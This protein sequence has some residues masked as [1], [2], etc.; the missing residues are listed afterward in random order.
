MTFVTGTEA[1]ASVAPP[2]L[3]LA[4]RTLDQHPDLYRVLRRMPDETC[5]GI[6]P[7]WGGPSETAL[8][9]PTVR[10][11][12][13]VDVET[14]GLDPLTDKIIEFAAVKFTFSP[15]TGQ[16]LD[17]V[18]M[19]QSYE[20]PGIAIPP[21]I[22][23][24]TGITDADV[25]GKRIDDAE[26]THLLLDCALVVAYHA[27]FDRQM[28]ERRWVAFET[29]PWACSLE[30]VDWKPFGVVGR[31]LEHCALYAL[32]EF[33]E[34]HGALADAKAGVRVLA[35]AHRNG[36][37]AFSFLL[38][39]ARTPRV[40]LYAKDAPFKLKGKLKQRGYRWSD[41]ES[42]RPKAWHLDVAREKLYDE[43]EWLY[44][45]IYKGWSRR[46]TPWL[47]AKLTPY[48]RY[49]NRI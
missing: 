19:Y 36:R 34:A 14:T 38:E 4:A 24:L 2:F 7:V 49:S 11:G 6:L 30:D 12:L 31:A 48:D 1:A 13:F 44:Q 21:E 40:R 16:I 23:E 43:Y 37:T 9:R 22:T 20:D 42:G 17:I 45:H 8:P 28:I 41:G 18:D 29:V 25:K 27:E 33:Y 15:E 32:G 26:I 35:R 3:D 5:F 46:A 39:S 10:Y 47:E